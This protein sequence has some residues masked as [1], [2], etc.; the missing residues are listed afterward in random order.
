MV[1]KSYLQQNKNVNTKNLELYIN[2]PSN[3]KINLKDG[4]CYFSG[5]NG[6]IKH[7]LD[8]NINLDILENNTI[9][10]FSKI[11]IIKKNNYSKIFSILNTTKIL[12]KNYVEGLYK[13]FEKTI[14]LKGIGYKA[15]IKNNFLILYIG[16]SHD[17]KMPIPN[18]LKVEVN[19]NTNI[20]IKGVSKEKI[21][22]FAA[23]IKLKRLPEPYKGNGIKYKTDKIKIKTPKKSK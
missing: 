5:K 21:G 19:S 9:K 10:I 23:N 3:I 18:D 14:I 13:L 22:Q 20:I 8:N 11:N 1:A 16:Y 4:Y 15:E 6:E 12:F 2:I 7:K 17:I